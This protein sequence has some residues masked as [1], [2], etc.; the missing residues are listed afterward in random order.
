MQRQGNYRKLVDKY[1][2]ITIAA[3]DHRGS[4]KKS[5]RPGDPGSVT[6]DEILAW[7]KRLVNLYKEEVS[8]ILIDPIYGKTVIDLQAPC[9][10]MLSMEKT[11]YRGEQQA[12]ETELLP[13]WTVRQARELGAV[14]VKLLLYYDPQNV[15]LAAR[16]RGIAQTVANDCKREG[17]VFL[18]EPL[19]YSKTGM[20]KP[21]VVLETAKELA[22]LDVDIFKFEYPGDEV[23][24]AKITEIVKKPWVLL[25]AG[26]EYNAY[27]LALKSAMVGGASGFAVGR[28]VWQE[29]GNYQG[30]EREKYFTDVALPRMRK[31]IKVVQNI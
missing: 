27:E 11:G 5:L 1:G 30:E 29:F 12:R 14:G 21:D 24:C 19:S 25:S 13:N 4:L 15:K 31:L 2:K 8:G 26:M 3:I 22:Y 6:E 17:M 10:W 20:D 7:K 23:S 28:A 16:Q 9:G 18:L